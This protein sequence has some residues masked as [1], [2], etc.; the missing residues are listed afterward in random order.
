VTADGYSTE[1]CQVGD[2][3]MYSTDWY[4]SIIVF[5]T[6]D[7]PT[8]KNI[9]SV[10]LE[11]E[12][13]SISGV[14]QRINVDMNNGPLGGSTVLKPSDFLA[15]AT[16]PNVAS[17]NPEVTLSVNLPPSTFSGMTKFP[18]AFRLVAPTT[19]TFAANLLTLGC[20]TSKLTVTYE[21]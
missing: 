7:L 21:Q 1:I 12:K 16:Y 14:V 17:F 4:R 15:V 8:L 5:P 2:K 11:V 18:T 10:V 19:A 13:L 3:G 9:I 6:Q 20:G